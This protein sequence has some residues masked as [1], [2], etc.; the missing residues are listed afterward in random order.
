MT[1]NTLAKLAPALGIS[2]YYLLFGSTE[3][4]EPTKMDIMLASLT[5]KERE[6]AEKLLCVFIEALTK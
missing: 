6:Y 4:P 5:A 2:A 1:T 3:K